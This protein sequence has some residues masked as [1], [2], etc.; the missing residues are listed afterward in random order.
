MSEPI[1]NLNLNPY[2]P[3]TADVD[4]V[5]PRE[6]GDASLIDAGRG[7][8]LGAAIV[9]FLLL[10]ASF[11][12]GFLIALVGRGEFAARTVVLLVVFILPLVIYQWYLI[13][14]T[15]Q[16]LGKKWLRIRIV[17]L[18]G[19]P[20]NF[21]SGV[22]LRNWVPWFVMQAMGRMLRSQD[23][24]ANAANLISLVDV[25]WIFGGA[26]RCVHDYLAGTRVVEA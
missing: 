21:V 18:D 8:R 7:S 19:T 11:I 4:A 6:R 15:G 17:K 16:T 14:T 5:W 13:S 25:L 3:P 22:L 2:S 10:I 23:L 9:D 12:P 1:P 20:V 24:S 26:S